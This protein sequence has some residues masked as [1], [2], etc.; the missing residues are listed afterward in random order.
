MQRGC[1][2]LGHP[3]PVTDASMLMFC[4]SKV[5]YVKYNIA[6]LQFYVKYGIINIW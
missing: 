5:S 3:L 6:I 4:L 2:I 1:P